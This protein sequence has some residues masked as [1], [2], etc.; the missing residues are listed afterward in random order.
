VEEIDSVEVLWPD[1]R[2]QLLTAVKANQVLL[3]DYA[4]AKTRPLVSQP[5]AAPL[6]TEVTDSSWLQYVHRENQQVDF[7][8]QPLLPHMHS[9]LG[10]GLTVGDVNGD[11]LED[12]YLGGATG[13]GGAMFVQ[14]PDGHFSRVPASGI[15]SLSEET[16]V[17]F[18]DSDGDKDVDLYVGSGGSD[19]RQGSALYEDKLYL[20]DGQGNF[21]L[22]QGALPDRRESTSVVVAADYDRDGDLDLFVGAR[23]Q[24]GAYPM[25]PHSALLRNESEK[26]ECRFTDVTAQVAKGLEKIGMVSGGLW[27]DYDGDG[28]VDLLVAGEFMPLVFFHNQKGKLIEATTTGLA[29][30]RGWWNSVVAADFDKDGDT[31]YMAGNLGLN[32]RYK[33]TV[34]EPLCIYASDYNKDG[35][36]D[37]VMSYYNGEE[38]YILH[39][40]DEL[41][42]Q[43]P[44]M[45]ARFRSY[46]SYAEASFEES[47]LPQE[48]AAA[49]VVCSEWMES[50]YI[51]NKGGGRFSLKALPIEA[52]LG[53]IYGMVAADYDGDGLEDVLAIG[54]SYATEVATGRYDALQGLLLKGDGKGGFRVVKARESGF[55]AGKDGKG[56]ARIVTGK[57]R[58]V[59]VVGNNG[60]SVQVYGV[61]RKAARYYTA[62]AMDAYAQVEV[63]NGGSYK[64]EF[65][66]GS[67]YL[68]HSSRT[69]PVNQEIKKIT[70]TDFKGN[71]RMIELN[72]QSSSV[73][74]NK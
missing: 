67:S 30:S 14:A 41:V 52:Q 7:K 5:A 29:H 17:L 44:A 21:T 57:G 4:Q 35:R 23:L 31:D 25:T 11:G 32:T 27:S 47:F 68:S 53:P 43:I 60:D 34:K 51:E 61:N 16:G 37:P 65:Y 46:K 64:Q 33:A 54:N 69:L 38:K 73:T 28:W 9:R 45:R 71:S 58:E 13:Y 72:P 63:S 62:Q 20:N 59:V 36:V 6:F 15:D 12:V 49:Y 8:S 2:Y 55:M 74:L 24:P 1:G 26:G 50:S 66:H 19:Q 10:P 70:V 18:F 48:L 42:D 3:V 22:A 39:A 56:M 40:R